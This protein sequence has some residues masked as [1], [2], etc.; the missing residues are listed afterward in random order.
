MTF[1]YDV[2]AGDFRTLI[3]KLKNLDAGVLSNFEIFN[4]AA[5][6]SL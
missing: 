1:L 3:A 5:K 6:I 4:C 2:F